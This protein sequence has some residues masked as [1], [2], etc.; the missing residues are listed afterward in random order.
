MALINVAS[1][2]PSSV[3][4]TSVPASPGDEPDLVYTILGQRG[5][6]AELHGWGVTYDVDQAVYDA[7]VAAHPDQ[8]GFLKTVTQADVDAMIADQSDPA[9]YGH[10]AGL[11]AT[12]LPPISIGAPVVTQAGM[13]LNTTN[14][15]WEEQIDSY[16]YQWTV[17]GVAV[18]TSAA[19]YTAVAGDV[20]KS[21]SCVV[22][23][24]N[25][26]GSTQSP[27]APGITIL[28]PPVNTTVPVVQQANAV[29]NCN[30]GSWT[31]APT[32]YAYQWQMNAANVG[33]NNPSYTIQAADVG[34]TAACTVTAT[35]AQG[36]TAAPLS[37]GIVVATPAAWTA[38]QLMGSQ[39]ADPAALLASISAITDGGFAITINGT[40]TQA[41]ATDFTGSSDLNIVAALIGGS[42]GGS[43]V[44]RCTWV[45]GVNNFT[46][47]TT[48]TG[49]TA[50]L[51]AGSPPAAGTD[52]STLCGFTLASGAAV[53]NGTGG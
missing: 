13:V 23:A 11:P 22:T 47:A 37:A 51:S 38:A 31:G 2:L 10:E 45:P 50:T 8:A 14:G 29:I 36:S 1:Q 18:G 27:P 39:I 32:G 43:S 49:V 46:I 28:G 19:S 6:P 21:G 42:L 53:T 40:V 9:N 24:T 52:I 16:A 12:N 30:T 48:R 35:N 34:A 33:G 25:T 4:M 7:Y 44:V 3:L 20:G 41:A 5:A 17:D 15:N 26:F